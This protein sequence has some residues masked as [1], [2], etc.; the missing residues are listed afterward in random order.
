MN[1]F[2]PFA[3]IPRFNREVIVTEKIDGTNAQVVIG[4]DGSF[5]TGS[6]NKWIEPHDDNYGFS[7]WAHANKECLLQL[8]PGA[9]FGEWWGNGIQ[10]GY[11][12]P[13]K[14]FSLFNTSRWTNETV[15]ACC[16]VVPILWIGLL[17]Q[18]NMGQILSRLFEGGSVAAPGFMNPEGIVI[19]H[20]AA[21]SYFKRAIFNDERGKEEQ[22]K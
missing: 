19:F 18:I 11:G 7:K 20:V 12:R 9:H 21:R 22:N 17:E 3:K 5:Q 4:E 10:R 2:R 1:D 15:P 14:R 8:G 13:D 6:R 16:S